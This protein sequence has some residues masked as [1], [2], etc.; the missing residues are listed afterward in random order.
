MAK[1]EVYG[2]R[3][4]PYCTRARRLLDSKGVEYR[5]IDVG[6]D[7]DLYQE[8]MRLSGGHTVPQIFID[9]QPIGGCDDM[10]ALDHQGRLDAMLGLN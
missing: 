7:S 1:V 6:A 3:S 2:T 8:M 4:C 10:Y 5:W 9:D